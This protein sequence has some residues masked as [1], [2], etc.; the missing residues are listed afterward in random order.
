MDPRQLREFLTKSYLMDIATITPEG[1]PH[2]TPVWFD[3][4][5]KIFLVSTERERKKSRNI[6]RHPKV[7]F[8]IAQPDLPY[9]AVVGYGD[10][11]IVDDPSSELLIRLARKYLPLAKADKYAEELKGD[12]GTRIILK[13]KPRWMLSWTG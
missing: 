7:G 6:I 1:Y 4:D 13:I 3:Y 2:V 9:A 11:T 10:V 5:G 8:S 12:G